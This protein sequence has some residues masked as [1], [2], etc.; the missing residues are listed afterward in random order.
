M[1]G[2]GRRARRVADAGARRIR[3]RVPGVT[4]SSPD[5]NGGIPGV[6][7]DEGANARTEGGVLGPGTMR[8]VKRIVRRRRV[9]PFPRAGRS[10]RGARFRLQAGRAPLGA[11]SRR[12]S[13]TRA[14]T[15]PRRTDSRVWPTSARPRAVAG[16]RRSLRTRAGHPR[17]GAGAD[18]GLNPNPTASREWD[19]PSGSAPRSALVTGATAGKP[20]TPGQAGRPRR[21]SAGTSARARHPPP[22]PQQGR[23]PRRA[24]TTTSGPA[25]VPLRPGGRPLSRSG[26]APAP[27]RVS[28]RALDLTVKS[29]EPQTGSPP[30]GPP[31]ARRPGRPP[32]SRRPIPGPGTRWPWDGGPAAGPL[33]GRRRRTRPQNRTRSRQEPAAA[34]GRPGPDAGQAGAAAAGRS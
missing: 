6:T 18:I 10:R 34:P 33:C 22:A 11:P 17:P 21:W 5:A 15:W 31:V 30:A 24:R 1:S 12:G 16:A 27:G 2:R 25:P 32:V 3:V 9:D 7:R 26:C 19:R 20:K 4:G 29:G 23:A 13:R 28:L 8:A 14:L